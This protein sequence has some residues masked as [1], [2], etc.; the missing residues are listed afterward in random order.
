MRF[1]Q[2][3]LFSIIPMNF[4]LDVSAGDKMTTGLEQL[5]SQYQHIKQS[6]LDKPNIKPEDVHPLIENIRKQST[7]PVT[8]V[9][10]SFE[11]RPIFK[12]DIG[13]G[14]LHV[15]MW[16]QMHGDEPTA[17]ASLFDLINYIQSPDNKEWVNGWSS[18]LTL[19][20]VPMLNPDGAHADRR[21]NAQGIDINRDAKRLQTPEGQTLSNLADTIKP[22]FGFNLHDQ[23]RFYSTGKS[24]NTATISVLAPAYNDEKDINESR[25]NAMKLIG[26]LNESLQKEIPNRVG[27]YNDT[28]SFRAFG[29]L[30]SSKGIAT[31]LIESGHYPGDQNRQTARWSTFMMLVQSINLINNGRYADGTLDKYRSIPMNRNFGLVDILLKNIDINA[32]TNGQ[33][34]ADLSINYNRVFENARI[35]EIGDLSANF[36][37][38]TFDLSGYQLQASKGFLLEEHLLLTDEVYL[39]LLSKGFGY[40]EGDKEL[41]KLETELPVMINP[42]NVVSKVPQRYQ[43]ANLFFAK[44]GQLKKVMING[45]MIDLN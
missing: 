36:A 23:G 20:L 43:L 13:S 11:Q 45:E 42:S 24:N 21:H 8:Q 31:T 30:L 44:A 12:I 7:F 37:L 4:I 25:G 19:H 32:N 18:R 41:L 1:L 3:I 33:Y 26:L 10:Q 22:K 40:F 34:H 17:T 29:D 38:E 5:K 2:A 16:S 14:P 15:L 28:Y 6:G 35:R 39:G 9:G 27:R